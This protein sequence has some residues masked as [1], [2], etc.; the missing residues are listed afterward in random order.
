MRAF[1]PLSVTRKAHSIV[2]R[3]GYALER[4]GKEVEASASYSRAGRAYDAACDV[5]T[6]I[7]GSVSSAKDDVV[8]HSTGEAVLF[9]LC[10]WSK[11]NT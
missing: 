8:L 6:K 10:L 9:R 11:A 5:I 7:G 3:I 1:R 4:L 2:R